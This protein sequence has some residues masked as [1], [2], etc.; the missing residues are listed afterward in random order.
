MIVAIDIDHFKQINDHWGHAAGDDALVALA[1]A[2]RTLAEPLGGDVARMGGDEFLILLPNRSELDARGFANQ[3]RKALAKTPA[4]EP[5]TISLGL[6][7]FNAGEADYA[8]AA[9]RADASLY[10]AKHQGRDRVAA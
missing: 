10:Q 9:R 2:A 6:A 3:L 8:A 5:W 7:R 4:S 1:R